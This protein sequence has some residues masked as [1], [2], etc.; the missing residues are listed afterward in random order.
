MCLVITK[1]NMYGKT[2]FDSNHSFIFHIQYSAPKMSW[3]SHIFNIKA[4]NS[5]K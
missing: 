4:P 2:S 3:E 5:F 1:M